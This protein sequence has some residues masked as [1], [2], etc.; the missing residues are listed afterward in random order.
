MMMFEYPKS[1]FDVFQRHFAE[2][3]EFAIVDIQLDFDTFIPLF[4][5]S[6]IGQ[7]FVSGSPYAVFGMSGIELALRFYHEI[8]GA[9]WSDEIQVQDTRS[10]FYWLGWMMCEI[11]RWF[12]ISL[13]RVPQIFPMEALLEMYHPFH[14]MDTSSMMLSL[15]EKLR[16]SETQL[17]K[18]RHHCHLTQEQLA[19]Q[20]GVHLRSI[21]MYEQR[22]N[23]ISKAQGIS[24]SR[25][26][27]VLHCRIEDLLEPKVEIQ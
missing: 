18:F 13:D 10:E 17:A 8:Y 7:D 16:S 22:H 15:S 3:M 6:Q 12:S 23:D 14:E 19:Q 2:A 1:D 25:M 5:T 20:S 21:Q 9:Y 24:L 4:L 26:S 11:T 27:K